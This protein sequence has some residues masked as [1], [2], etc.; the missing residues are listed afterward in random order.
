[1][2]EN[3]NAERLRRK[4]SASSVLNQLLKTLLSIYPRRE[5]TGPE[6][7]RIRELAEDK[8]EGEGSE[9]EGT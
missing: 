2:I 1:M 4:F 9:E 5:I 6:K 7:G 8:E 3:T